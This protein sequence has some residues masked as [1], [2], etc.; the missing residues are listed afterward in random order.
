MKK[1]T[2]VSFSKI[3]NFYSLFFQIA[4]ETIPYYLYNCVFHLNTVTLYFKKPLRYTFRQPNNR[5]VNIQCQMLQV[6]Q[7]FSSSYSHFSMFMHGLVSTIN[8]MQKILCR[9]FRS[10][11]TTSISIN[12]SLEFS[13][14]YLN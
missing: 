5:R 13:H 14:L 7:Y 8:I 12:S 9:S 4:L 1:H 10:L 2:L 3:S 11:S 6:F